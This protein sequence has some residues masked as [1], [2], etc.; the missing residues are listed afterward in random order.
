[1][2]RNRA[3]WNDEDVGGW[4]AA[5]LTASAGAVVP[6]TTNSGYGAYVLPHAEDL[7]VRAGGD[8]ARL[9]AG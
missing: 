8:V 3:C 9:M 4:V 2:S 6:S 5:Y 7:G 1:M